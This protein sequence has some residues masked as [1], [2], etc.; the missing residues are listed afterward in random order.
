MTSH[1]HCF[2]LILQVHQPGNSCRL[3]MSASMN[4]CLKAH[5]PDGC[6]IRTK[7]SG[8]T[9]VIMPT[10]TALDPSVEPISRESSLVYVMDVTGCV[11]TKRH[12]RVLHHPDAFTIQNNQCTSK[13]SKLYQHI[14]IQYHGSQ[15]SSLK[16]GMLARIEVRSSSKFGAL[17]AP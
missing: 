14:I 11:P 2:V 16:K 7:R 1:S 17:D 13:G 15:L 6:S 10:A 4:S 9:S 8:R 3:P 12:P 5:D